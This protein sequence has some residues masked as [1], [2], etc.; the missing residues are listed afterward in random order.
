MNLVRFHF[1]RSHGELVSAMPLRLRVQSSALPDGSIIGAIEAESLNV[2]RALK[3]IQGL[4][5]LP[6]PT[7]PLRA[8][9]LAP[10]TGRGLL[11][12]G[13]AHSTR[14]LLVVLHAAYGHWFLDPDLVS[15][16]VGRTRGRSID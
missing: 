16:G 5:V 11:A 12:P 13:D 1:E 10:F 3:G 14:D 6:G 7:T 15:L 8:E 2:M 4:T 9:H